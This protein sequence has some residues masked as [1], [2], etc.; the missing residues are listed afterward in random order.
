M[1]VAAGQDPH[2]RDGR[3]ACVNE[4]G[5]AARRGVQQTL[6]QG[7]QLLGELSGVSELVGARALGGP[8]VEVSGLALRLKGL[9][10]QLDDP[11]G[12]S[13]AVDVGAQ[14][15]DLVGRPLVVP[16][17]VGDVVAQGVRRAHELG[18][19]PLGVGGEPPPHGLGDQEGV[20]ERL[21]GAAQLDLQT[22]QE[23]I[24][25]A[26]GGR[27]AQVDTRVG[28]EFGRVLGRMLS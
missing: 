14:V 22:A 6:G 11:Q 19:D 10:V 17:A 24:G 4:L 3:P 16:T 8:A 15:G 26:D 25:I 9:Q 20:L 7:R 13:D 2:Q 23:V 21:P 18:G 1:V 5:L 27:G 12:M 28:A